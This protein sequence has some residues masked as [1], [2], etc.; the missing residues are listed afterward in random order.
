MT[1][2]YIGDRTADAIAASGAGIAFGWAS[3][4]YGNEEPAYVTTR[5]ETFD[6]ILQL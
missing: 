1:V 5:L 2:Y 6:E 3:Y 4:G